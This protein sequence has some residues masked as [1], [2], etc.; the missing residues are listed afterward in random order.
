[1]P[2]RRGRRYENLFGIGVPIIPWVSVVVAV[3]DTLLLPSV[4]FTVCWLVLVLV[5]S[6]VGWWGRE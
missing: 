1:M 4:S 3:A 2:S 5:A 6:A